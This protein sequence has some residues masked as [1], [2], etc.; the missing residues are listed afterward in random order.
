MGKKKKDKVFKGNTRIG[1]V[2]DRSGSMNY[3]PGIVLEY[4]GALET[5]LTTLKSQPNIENTTIRTVYF[6]DE[7]E[8]DPRYKVADAPTPVI[9]PR[10]RTALYDATA[11]MIVDIASDLEDTDRALIVVITDGDEN[12]STEYRD[13]NRL[14]KLMDGKQALDNWTFVFLATELDGSNARFAGVTGATNSS[15]YNKSA[16]GLRS[17]GNTLSTATTNYH[18]GTQASIKEDFFNNATNVVDPK[19]KGTGKTPVSK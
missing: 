3:P 18:A 19:Q 17:M 5:W 14:K 16:V 13:W 2:V 4:N 7:L 6:D 8:W 12:A 15:G 11:A 9:H 10:N 1:L